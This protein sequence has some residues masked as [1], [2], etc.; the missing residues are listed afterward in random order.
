MTKEEFTHLLATWI[1]CKTMRDMEIS[2]TGQIRISPSPHSLWAIAR[3]GLAVV[4]PEI[5]QPRDGCVIVVIV[6]VALT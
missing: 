1:G 2:V 4:L 5:S 6:D 3:T